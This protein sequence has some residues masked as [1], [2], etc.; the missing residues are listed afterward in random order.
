MFNGVQSGIYLRVSSE[1]TRFLNRLVAFISSDFVITACPTTTS[2]PNR[3]RRVYKSKLSHPA[4]SAIRKIRCDTF[5]C[6]ASVANN[7]LLIG[8]HPPC[9][10][11]VALRQQLIH[12]KSFCCS[13][14]PVS[15]SAADS[16]GRTGNKETRDLPSKSA[17]KMSANVG[18]INST[19]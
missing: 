16:S 2:L 12:N 3:G 4:I 15:L 19:C 6:C 17:R 8:S 11:H 13:F 9:A 10:S 18:T 1:T 7:D 5:Y 14:W